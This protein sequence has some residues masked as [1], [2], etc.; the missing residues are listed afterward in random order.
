M[1]WIWAAV[2][3]VALFALAWFV[4]GRQKKKF[5]NPDANGANTGAAK[6]YAAM[7]DV[8]REGGGNGPGGI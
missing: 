8:R 5:G 4:S 1:F 3:V 7:K 6:G 2:V